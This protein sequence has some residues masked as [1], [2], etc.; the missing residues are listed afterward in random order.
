[1]EQFEFPAKLDEDNIYQRIFGYVSCFKCYQ[2][3]AY[4]A[5]SGTTR[6]KEHLNKCTKI[7]FSSSSSITIDQSSRLS[8][9]QSTLSH[10][11][12]KKSSKLNEKDVHNMKKL[13]AQ[14]VCRDIRSFSIVDDSGFRSVA[15]ELIR[16][17]MLL[18]FNLARSNNTISFRT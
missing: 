8:S 1:M 17:G 9:T 15:Q 14:W 10:H 6:I 2:T 4:S 18:Y 12:F 7:M 11:G 3:F 5:K 16:I 13:C